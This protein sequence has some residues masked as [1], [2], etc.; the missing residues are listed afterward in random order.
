[1]RSGRRAVRAMV[2]EVLGSPHRKLEER[3][4]TV[5]ISSQSVYVAEYDGD[6]EVYEAGNYQTSK[7]VHG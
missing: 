2:V 5:W 6:G 4:T 7:F 3:R 1:M